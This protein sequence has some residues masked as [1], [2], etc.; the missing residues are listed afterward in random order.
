MTRI[1]I[2]LLMIFG[3]VTLGLYL[4]NFLF[5]DIHTNIL[6]HSISFVF[7]LLLILIIIRVSKNTGRALA[8]YGR[9]GNVKRMETN[10]LVRQGVYKYMRH[11]M[12]LGLLFFPLSIALLIG[13]PSFILLIAPSEMIIILILIKYF[14][15]PEAIKKFGKEYL[16][17]KNE[18]PWFCFKINC[19]KALLKV[20]PKN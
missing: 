1:F 19:L 4:D 3:G 7:G 8:K 17:Y 10:V 14:E 13:S 2:W 15:E 16:E 9:R 5:K 11:P 18:L 20:V 6:F 12:H